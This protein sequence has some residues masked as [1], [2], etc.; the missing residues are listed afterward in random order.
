VLFPPSVA[1][2][3]RRRVLAAAVLLSLP[4]GL[5]VVQALDDLALAHQLVDLMLE[6]VILRVLK[7]AALLNALLSYWGGTL[8]R[9]TSWR[10]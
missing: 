10:R 4:L 6:V 5:L 8:Y 3:A 7:V 2:P 1:L 9:R